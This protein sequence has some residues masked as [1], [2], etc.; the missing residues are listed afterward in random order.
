VALNDEDHN[1]YR[2]KRGCLLLAS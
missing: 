2:H 1:V